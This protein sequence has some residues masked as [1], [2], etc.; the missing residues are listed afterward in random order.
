M[1]CTQSVHTR[2]ALPPSR[3]DY[4]LVQQAAAAGAQVYD[5]CQIRGLEAQPR[6]LAVRTEGLAW[7]E[8]ALVVGDAAGLLEPFT[9][10]GIY[11]ALRSAWLASEALTAASVSDA[12]PWSY[13]AA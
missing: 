1:D 8:R 10:E 4:A 3:F 9:G 7:R 2:Q 12:S 13:E 5:A 6:G 11:Y